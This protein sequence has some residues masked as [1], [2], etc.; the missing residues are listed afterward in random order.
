MPDFTEAEWELIFQQLDMDP[1]GY[2]MPVRR[3]KSVVMA[4]WNIRKFGSLT[5]SRN[6]PSRTDGAW[7]IIVNFCKRCD[8]VAIQEVQDSTDCLFHLQE[9]LGSNYEVVLTDIAGGVPGKDYMRERLAFVFRTNRITHTAL[10]SDISFERSALL[11]EIYD[12]REEFIQAFEQREQDLQEWTEKNEQR[13]AEGKR[14]LS[15]PPFVLP[16]FV[17][18]IRTPQIASFEVKPIGDAEP[19]EFLAVNAHLLYGDKSKQKEERE[20]EFKALLAWLINRAKERGRKYAKNLMLLGDLNLDFEAA[21][22]RREA[23]NAFIRDLNDNQLKGAPAKVNFPFIDKHPSQ[24]EV[25]RTNARK[26][27]TYD[28]IA[29]ISDDNR[30]PPSELNEQAGSLGAND[31][32]YGMFDFVRLFFDTFPALQQLPKRNRYSK[33]E[34][35]VSD[36]MPIWIRLARPFEGQTEHQW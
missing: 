11:D 28:Q 36:H 3:T 19:Y 1:Q 26:D 10:A 4:S 29:L 16:R 27:Q 25:F 6:R 18:F 32:D 23:I 17:Q 2:G 8:F 35:D 13:E 9:Q 21:D 34:Y 31:F 30:L 24:D 5:D 7:K 12:H 22:I 33:F 20:L 14:K 15:K